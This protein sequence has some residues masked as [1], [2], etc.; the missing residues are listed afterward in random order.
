MSWSEFRLIDYYKQRGY[1]VIRVGKPDLILL[2]DNQIE[3]VEVK[4]KND[5][6]TRNQKRAFKLLERHGFEPRVEK[7]SRIENT[8]KIII[9]EIQS[10]L[11][12][13]NK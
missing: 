5:K 13:A 12:K 3:F 1:D 10:S 2:K 7:V 4:T 11:S 9:E 6:L 8:V